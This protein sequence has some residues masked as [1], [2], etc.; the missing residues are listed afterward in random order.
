MAN[1][2]SSQENGV[3]LKEEWIVV[4][5]NIGEEQSHTMSTHQVV[6]SH[7]VPVGLSGV[8]EEF[9]FLGQ[10]HDGLSVLEQTTT[11]VLLAHQIEASDKARELG[12]QW[13]Q[14]ESLVM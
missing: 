1:A 7:S 9:H 6:V 8:E 2:V 14:G 5:D 12:L 13:G 3:D 4:G 10:S 11:H